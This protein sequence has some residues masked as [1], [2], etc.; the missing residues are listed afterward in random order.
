MI[1]ESLSDDAE[2]ESAKFSEEVNNAKSQL[3]ADKE[4]EIRRKLVESD[5]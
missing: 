5:K 2:A 3:L 4:A 1:P